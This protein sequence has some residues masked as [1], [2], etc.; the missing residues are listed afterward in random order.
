MPKDQPAAASLLL[1]RPGVLVTVGTV[2]RSGAAAPGPAGAA[3]RAGWVAAAAVLLAA[4]I[5]AYRFAVGGTLL[6]PAQ[7]SQHGRVLMNLEGLPR[8]GWKR[9]RPARVALL[10]DRRGA[11]YGIDQGP[12]GA[13]LRIRR[14]A[15]GALAVMGP[16]VRLPSGAYA[17]RWTEVPRVTELLLEGAGGVGEGRYTLTCTEP[18]RGLDG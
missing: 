17:R 11:D 10:G 2:V 4:V 12:G 16:R 8:S 3:R 5:A 1:D 9:L 7:L 6:V 15:R 18:E 14:T 13:W